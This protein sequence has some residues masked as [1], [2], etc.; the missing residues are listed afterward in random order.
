MSTTEYSFPE[1][2]IECGGTPELR[3]N[4]YVCTKCGHVIAVKKLTGQWVEVKSHIKLETNI[5]HSM[6]LEKF[7][8]M[9][10]EHPRKVTLKFY[11]RDLYRFS[12]YNR[13]YV[14]QRLKN[15]GD[16]LET[17]TRG[18]IKRK[19]DTRRMYHYLEIV[20]DRYDASNTLLEPLQPE[21]EL[22]K[23]DLERLIQ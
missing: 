12:G 8:K 20:R 17:V 6:I 19:F 23:L 15:A 16:E 21:V 4:E 11:T 18:F 22:E 10:K 2:C 14:S 7:S 5:F 1:Y 9:I 13:Y 3:E